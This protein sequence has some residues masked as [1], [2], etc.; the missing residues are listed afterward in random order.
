VQNIDRLNERLKEY[1]EQQYNHT[2]LLENILTL[3]QDENDRDEDEF[4]NQNFTDSIKDIQK[5]HCESILEHLVCK[6]KFYT[7]AKAQYSLINL[8]ETGEFDQ[9]NENNEIVALA[10]F[11]HLNEKKTVR[12][13]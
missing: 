12:I 1:T 9:V 8:H 3:K 5:Y 11:E 7:I 4:D 10:I 2:Y 6:G 13:F